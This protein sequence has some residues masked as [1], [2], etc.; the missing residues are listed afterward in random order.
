MFDTLTVN[1]TAILRLNAP[2]RNVLTSDLQTALADAMED[3]ALSQR[4]NAVIISTALPDFSVGADVREHL[5]RESCERMLRAAHR[6]IAAVLRHP[7]PVVA[8]VRGHCLGGAFELALACDQLIATP[9][10]RLGLP[11]ISLGCYPPAATVLMPSR[12]P[13]WLARDLLMTG[14]AFTARELAA[15]GAGFELTEDLDTAI[16]ELAARYTA[17]P[18][19]PLTETV[20]LTRS[21]EAERFES[22]VGGLERNYLDRLMRMRDAREGPE[23]F[24]AKRSPVWDHLDEDGT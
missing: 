14:R 1:R 3:M 20:R 10:S 7:V 24:L 12:L 16:A 13:A 11:E 22:A 4:H 18:R 23:A 19:G 21:G 17:L 9:D 6:L 8:C 15:R 5:G 2:P